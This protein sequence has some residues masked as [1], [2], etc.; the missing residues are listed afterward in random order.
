M[1]W[2]K[3]RDVHLPHLDEEVGKGVGKGTDNMKA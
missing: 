3:M 2:K 1:G